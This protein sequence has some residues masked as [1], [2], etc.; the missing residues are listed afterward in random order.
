MLFRPQLNTLAEYNESESVEE[1]VMMDDTGVIGNSP[2]RAKRRLASSIASSPDTPLAPSIPP[3]LTVNN[4]R[5]DQENSKDDTKQG[6]ETQLMRIKGGVV[7]KI[8]DIRGGGRDEDVLCIAPGNNN[9]GDSSQ[10]VAVELAHA[11]NEMFMCSLTEN[12]FR[13]YRLPELNIKANVS[14]AGSSAKK[15]ATSTVKILNS[16]PSVYKK[17]ESASWWNQS[18]ED[19]FGD[20]QST[21][22][23][24][25][26]EGESSLRASTGRNINRSPLPIVENI[27]DLIAEKSSAAVEDEILLTT[28][29]EGPEANPVIDLNKARRCPCPPLCGVSFGRAGELVAFNNGPVK[30]MFRDFELMK[31]SSGNKPNQPYN[32]KPIVFNEITTST[33]DLVENEKKSEEEMEFESGTPRS[34]FDLIEMQ[35]AAKIAQ[36]GVEV[37]ND[38]TNSNAQ[39]SSNSSCA[40]SSDHHSFGESSDDESNSDDSDGFC[41]V[42][43]KFDDYFANSR[44]S[45]THVDMDTVAAEEQEERKQFSGIA[46]LAPNVFVTHKY[47][48]F[49]LNGQNPQIAQMLELGFAWWLLSDFSTPTSWEHS[50][51]IP[52]SWNEV[53]APHT[54]D[55]EYAR[56]PSQIESSR[57]ASMVGNLKKT[58]TMQSPSASIPADQRLCK[59]TDVNNVS[60]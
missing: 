22:T 2:F 60:F 24:H 19:V 8:A 59:F 56:Q 3:N 39:S 58:F 51:K 37:D 43:N 31:R 38:S 6:W 28:A 16:V 26:F 52:A 18:E 13:V 15:E 40:D 42:A 12:V 11:S 54:P 47:D 9:A 27:T 32:E 50:E 36:W 20:L 46:S 49:L 30:K 10:I 57:S 14:L 5:K 7:E 17:Q 4:H 45:L 21:Q 29:N 44:K 23:L 33:V 48:G 25:R 35:S 55:T 34:L 1:D 53:P 41:H